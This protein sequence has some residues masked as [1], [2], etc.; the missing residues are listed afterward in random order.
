M[1]NKKTGSIFDNFTR[2]YS[3]SK[4]LRFELK[5]VPRTK[6]MLKLGHKD[7]RIIFTEDKLRV[8]NYAIIKKY[9]DRLHAD[10]INAALS[11][12]NDYIDVSI[13]KNSEEKILDDQDEENNEKE[14]AVKS[15]DHKKIVKL[16]N[17]LSRSDKYS[18]W[19]KIDNKNKVSG[20]LFEKELID[21]LNEKFKDELDEEVEI[22]ILF[23]NKEEKGRKIKL[24]EV[25][26]SFGKDESGEGRDFTTYFTSAFHDNRKNYYKGDGKV[27][28]VATRIVDENLKRF[29]TNKK[30]F[31]NILKL[32][33]YE[34]GEKSGDR[35]K[36]KLEV[37]QK[38]QVLLNKF[39]SQ[40]IREEFLAVK[41]KKETWFDG[42]DYKTWE[43][44]VFGNNYSHF[45]Q[46]EINKYNFIIGKLNKDINEMSIGNERF[47]RLHKQVHGEVKKLDAEEKFYIDDEQILNSDKSFIKRFIGHSEVKLISSQKIFDR[48][49]REEYSDP[50]QVFISG[51]A[52]N[53]M[54]SR[55][56]VAWDT[57]GGAI[58]DYW[59][60]RE[61]T[62]R[63]K[64]PDFVD[65]Q[66]IKDVLDANG[67]M[68]ADEL[69][70]YKYF[71]KIN[72]DDK[73]EENERKM[74]KE[75]QSDLSEGNHW[76]N[77]LRIMQYEF[78]LLKETHNKKSS[79]L[80]REIS[81]KKGD[82]RQIALLFD[83]AESANGLM[84]MT[85]YFALRKKGVMI[86]GKRYAN[87]DDI[88]GWVENYLDGDD[89]GLEGECLIN[90][91]YKA[92]KNFVSQ[93]SWIEDK[94]VLNFGNALF[95][96]GWPES[97]E[98]VKGGIVLRKKLDDGFLYYL[99]VVSGQD[100]AFF[101][102]KALY[103]DIDN[104]LWQK[105]R[106]KQ[107]QNP[108]RMLPKNLVTPFLQKEPKNFKSVGD[109]KEW[110]K[111][112]S[113]EGNFMFNNG[114]N[115]EWISL[116]DLTK[117]IVTEGKEVEWKAIN[118]KKGTATKKLIEKG[119]NPTDIFLLNYLNGKHT[120]GKI[121][122]DYLQEYLEY[123][124]DAMP[125]YYGRSFNFP[126]TK[127]ST[128]T[129]FFYAWAQENI[130]DIDFIGISE[131][132][133][134]DLLINCKNN[135]KIYLFQIYNKD[136]ELDE[137]IGKEKYGDK[138]VSKREWRMQKNRREEEKEQ[139]RE[140]IHTSFFKLL[141]ND[142]NL[143]NKNGAV[144]KLSGGAKIFYRPASKDLKKK[145]D[146]YGNEISERKR[147]DQDHL[148]IHIP[149]VIN[150]VSKNDRWGMNDR[151]NE[152][153]YRTP[154]GEDNFRFIALDRGEKNLAYLS[155]LNEE[156][157]VLQL[158]SLNCITRYDKSGK[159]KKERNLYHDKNGNP[160]GD[161]VMEDYKDYQNL[162]DK[163]QIERL[164]ARKSWEPIEKIANLKEGYLGFVTNKIANL[165]IEIIREGKLPFVILENLNAGM[166]QGRIQIEKQVYSKIEEKI[167]KKLNYLVDKK[168]ANF[169]DGWQLTPPV[170]TY[171]EDIESKDQVGIM[172]Y[173]NPSYT[174]ATCPR[175]GF[176]KRKYIKVNNAKEGL[177]NVKIS[178]DGM[179]YTFNFSSEVRDRNGEI[180]TVEDKIYSNVRRV[181]WN[182]AKNG[183]GD[184]EEIQDITQKF[185]QL[186]EGFGIKPKDGDINNQ[187]G[188]ILWEKGKETEFW[189]KYLKWFNCL[190][191]IRNSINKKRELKDE[192][193]S[194]SLIEEWGEN[195]DFIFCP[196]CYFDSEN[197]KEWDKLK[198]DI[199]IDGEYPQN[200]EF[201]GDANGAFNI[202]RKGIISIKKIKDYQEA[203]VGFKHKWNIN[204]LPRKENEKIFVKDDKQELVLTL[205]KLKE[206][207]KNR[208]VLYY[209]IFNKNIKFKKDE[210]TDVEDI[211]AERRLRKYPDLFISDKEWDE[212]AQGQYK[213]N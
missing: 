176:R 41:V 203:L 48:L 37:T 212:F 9:I 200:V 163:K 21:V 70:K 68:R 32:S 26:N 172:F 17:Q 46:S 159:I 81:Y 180:L 153:I 120:K 55:Y 99:A 137:E 79:Q 19:V 198:Q 102:S 147:Y 140:N 143:K 199:F 89:D 126:E 7:S 201:N 121:D 65:L 61:K 94:V 80:L 142:C 31:E 77:F 205:I 4:T 152:S 83:F 166:K 91:Y 144:Y 116:N 204:N 24:R 124:K 13:S 5:P 119:I 125:K 8:E 150:F 139:G 11:S 171:G 64:I 131:S 45:L 161:V 118:R 107:L 149:I 10:F 188:K 194:E 75:L 114:K 30:K 174:S 151:I 54:S 62:P 135:K 20:R 50:K 115:W 57:F 43:D 59:N 162:L 113:N 169:L 35:E 130:Y 39:N 85:K 29:L 84:N 170:N 157:K 209:C 34:S 58:L 60:K 155:V 110:F 109:K 78:N 138:F 18:D 146:Q 67:E 154:F 136:F 186:F 189:K 22:P 53:T 1:A 192:D 122:Q 117:K 195:R 92:L 133:V 49:L 52:I 103:N 148:S 66:T 40:Q 196:H 15:D 88:H 63:K 129:T 202:G 93:K 197:R 44:Y 206:G 33:Q 178:Y 145:Q 16:F 158:E 208:D 25:F 128:D 184:S 175:C 76:H 207:K 190:L 123:L 179:K 27:G 210:Y 106:Y 173:V 42:F 213:N 73:N 101:E 38:Y 156:G 95:L 112:L 104:S 98:K 141:F 28:R 177:V 2:Q 47:L 74:L 86:E 6:E 23:F 187:I 97:Q 185:N 36:K 211:S 69:F 193:T 132:M 90:G 12:P 134:G 71:K 108:S 183:K 72:L 87:R 82:K 105:M 182:N 167:A 3:L 127:D 96:G 168:I 51:R 56:F 100:R 164:K 191:E 160:R 14:T 165:V 111:K 181:I